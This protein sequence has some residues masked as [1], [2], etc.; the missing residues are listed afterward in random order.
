LEEKYK[1]GFKQLFFGLLFLVIFLLFFSLVQTAQPGEFL[2]AEGKNNFSYDYFK[3]IYA[4]DL[5]LL[6]PDITAISYVENNVSYGYVNIF[7]G[8]GQNFVIQPGKEY[9]IIA[10]NK[11][12]IYLI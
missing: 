8:I 6:Y 5:V 9:E 7:G 10:K 12:K 4:E 3:P 2:L 1:M 11:I